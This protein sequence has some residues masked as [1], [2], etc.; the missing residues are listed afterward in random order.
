MYIYLSYGLGDLNNWGPERKRSNKG[1]NGR[2]K[3]SSYGGMMK[4]VRH[5]M[6]MLMQ[7]KENWGKEGRRKKKEER[8]RKKSRMT[9]KETLQAA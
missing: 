3:D 2:E 9:T 6:Q 5:L 8:R 7:T 4:L 1:K